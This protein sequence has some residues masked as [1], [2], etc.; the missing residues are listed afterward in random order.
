MAYI[1]VEHL[2]KLF[3]PSPEA[4]ALSM[5][6]QG[7]SKAEILAHTQCTL[8]VN[9]ATFE[10]QEGETF[11]IM[12]LSG[13]GKSTVLRCLNRL[14]EPTAGEVQLDGESVTQAT[15]QRLRQIRREQLAMV[16]QQFGLL[17]HRSVRDNVAFGLEIQKV[18]KARRQQRASEAI[19]MVGLAEYADSRVQALS[20]GMQQRVGLAR[21]LATDAPVLLMDEAFGALDPLIR[22]Q[23]QDELRVL[24]SRLRKTIVFITHDLDEALKLGD[25]VA[26][27][28]EG[29]IVQI[30]TPEQILLTPAT[31]YVREFVKN[32]N[33]ARALTARAVMA[34]IDTVA[35]TSDT[36]GAILQQ[37]ER[38]NWHVMAVTDEHG[39]FAGLA[40]V[41]EVRAAVERGEQHLDAIVERDTS[42]VSP[43]TLIADIL[44]DVGHGKHPMAVVTESDRIE[45]LI[46]PAHLLLAIAG[47]TVNAETKDVKDTGHHTPPPDRADRVSGKRTAATPRPEHDGSKEC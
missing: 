2:Y 15:A 47:E 20:G 44:A 46:T 14:I 24:Q 31:D 25:R 41:D 27:M 3:G 1:E 23:M 19:E 8:A 34:R 10:V 33:Y 42:T 22:T 45:G 28:N 43:D 18:P 16:F 26:I 36:P 7:R 17:P 13:S 5:A 11:V 37:M 35:N 9:D 39:C 40:R 38:R 30:G 12:G 32:V 4:D 21:A 6:R 29:A